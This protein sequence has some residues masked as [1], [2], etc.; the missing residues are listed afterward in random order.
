ML[1]MSKRNGG[2]SLREGTA[3][4]LRA[5]AESEGIP[6]PATAERP[7]RRTFTAEYK[8]SILREAD[9]A[10]ASGEGAVGGLLRREG[11]W[12]SHLAS[13]RR[14]RARGELAGL[15]PKRRGPK[16]ARKNL[17]ADENE[18]LRRQIARLQAELDK[19]KVIIDVQK[20][21]SLLLG[22]STPESPTEA[23]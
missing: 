5:A 1:D 22:I 19:A 3:G 2:A 13:W 21:L 4:A 15:K 18:K 23:S 10:A 8:Q 9:V 7:A 14:L 11:L 20:K 12:S 17:L 6:G 16:P